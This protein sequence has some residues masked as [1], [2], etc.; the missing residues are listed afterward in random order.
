MKLRAAIA[1]ASLSTGLLPSGASAEWQPDGVP[2]CTQAA[3]QLYSHAAA[4]GSG[5][6][7]VTWSDFRSG[8]HYDIFVQRVDA[9]GTPQWPLDGVA[10]CTAAHDQ[11]APRIIPDDSGG[12]ILTWYDRRNGAHYDIFAQR[13]NASGAMQWAADGVPVCAAVGDQ[14]SPE[15]VTDGAGGAIIVWD[16][17]R[18]GG[19]SPDV[20]VQRLSASGARLWTPNGVA[21]VIESSDQAGSRIDSDGAGGAVV[22]WHDYRSGTNYDLFSQRVNASGTPLWTHNGVTI[23]DLDVDQSFPNIA[24]DGSGGAIVAWNDPRDGVSQIFAQRVSAAGVIQWAEDG[25]PICTDVISQSYPLIVADDAGGAIATW[26]DARNGNGDVYA[27]R[28]SGSGVPL[29]A[30]EGLPLCT[31]ANHQV[32]PVLVR[33]GSGGCDRRVAR[34]AKRCGRRLRAARERRGSTAVGRRWDRGV[35]R[36]RRAVLAR[37]RRGRRRNGAGHLVRFAGRRRCGY[38][39]TTRGGCADVHRQCSLHRIGNDV[40]QLPESVC[41]N[42]RDRRRTAG[43]VAYRDRSLRSRGSES[44]RAIVR[45]GERW[46]AEVALRRSRRCGPLASQWGLLLSRSRERRHGQSQDGDRA[47]A[48][49]RLPAGISRWGPIGTSPCTSRRTRGFSWRSWRP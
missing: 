36:R 33:D 8:S 42:D 22:T 17:D 45:G 9:S 1:L 20:Y 15:P 32:N 19:F 28:V 3:E 26:A 4:D 12:A 39:R 21:L 34:L 30:G 41:D 49:V 38:L 10:A 7:I 14:Y 44:A 27:Q 31:A 46:S 47:V 13:V 23:S 29:W 2:I 35:H 48:A 16:D 11:I 43:G 37:D 25:V 6:A 18:T 5:G 24:S 40:L